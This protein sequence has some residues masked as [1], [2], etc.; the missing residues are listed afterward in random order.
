MDRLAS[1]PAPFSPAQA[2]ALRRAA[3]LTVELTAVVASVRVH[4]AELEAARAA[5]TPLPPSPSPPFAAPSPPLPAPPEVE[6]HVT[7]AAPGLE[8]PGLEAGELR[9]ALGAA[10][11]AEPT[12][13]R[14][15][16]ADALLPDS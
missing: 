10:R 11:D 14:P 2:A 4:L 1:R 8:E 13:P 7:S 9:A 3:E 6:P 15:R 5:A 12:R 16:W